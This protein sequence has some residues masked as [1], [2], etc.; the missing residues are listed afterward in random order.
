MRKIFI[1]VLVGGLGCLTVS[2][3]ALVPAPEPRVVNGIVAIVNGD[4]ITEKDARTFIEPGIQQ[5]G[6]MPFNSRQEYEQKAL[7]VYRDGLNQLVHRQLILNDFKSAGYNLPESIIEDFI[8][9]RIRDR[10]GDRVKL[11]KSLQEEGVTYETFRKEI[12][13][14]FVVEQMQL[15]NVSSAL[16]ISPYKIETYYKEHTNDYQLGDQVKVRVIVLNKASPEDQGRTKLAREI[17]KKIEEGATFAEMAGIYSDGSQRAAGG[18]WGWH[19]KVYFRKELADVAFTLKPGERSGLIDTPD[20]CYLM[21]VEERRAAGLK[22]VAEVREEI[23]KTLI[24]QE[25]ARLQKKYIERLKK[26]A[27]IRYF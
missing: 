27:F 1:T 12:R 6:K 25:R 9:D 23:E 14:Q 26:T 5:L 22:P 18:D 15:K 2:A 10:Y 21:L 24:A 16:V 13:D 20:A 17:L 8:R 3:Q 19:E 4:I 7:E 11:T